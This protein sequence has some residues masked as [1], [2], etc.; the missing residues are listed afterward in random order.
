MKARWTKRW[1]QN[2]KNNKQGKNF[3]RYIYVLIKD[4]LYTQTERRNTIKNPCCQTRNLS[5]GTRGRGCLI[6]LYIL[7]VNK[8]DLSMRD[9]HKILAQHSQNDFNPS[10]ITVLKE[11]WLEWPNTGWVWGPSI[12]TEKISG[13]N[14]RLYWVYWLI[15]MFQLVQLQ[16]GKSLKLL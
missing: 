8:K 10:I 7:T 14:S 9:M 3:I 6:F 5:H 12:R 15:W 13:L 16:S 11:R 2:C 1:A 4:L